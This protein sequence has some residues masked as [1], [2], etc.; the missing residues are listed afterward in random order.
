MAAIPGHATLA[1]AKKRLG[2]SGDDSV[3]LFRHGSLIVKLYAPRGSDRQRPHKQDEIYVVAH[4]RGEF[5]CAGAR[6][7]FGPGD[8]LF[9]PAGVEHRFVDFTEDLAVW[10]FFYGPEGGEGITAGQ[11]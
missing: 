7:S 4:G 1:E 10:V 3:E 8:V 5:H 9:A 11:R 2:Q 6:E